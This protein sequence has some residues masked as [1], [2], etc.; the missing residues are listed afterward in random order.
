[1]T[2]APLSRA[3]S[4]RPAA[5]QTSDDVPMD[6]N[7]S[8]SC[9]ALAAVFD[10]CGGI[11]SP[12]QT[13]PGRMNPPHP[14]Q[15]GHGS[16]HVSVSDNEVFGKAAVL[17]EIAVKFDNVLAARSLMES[18]HVLGYQRQF[19]HQLSKPRPARNDQDSA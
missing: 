14:G 18:V 12:N 11:D 17:K 4:A 5:G 1:M 10:A 15:Q 9:A 13:T 7:T 6:R 19:W 16:A 2:T 8:Q 3:V